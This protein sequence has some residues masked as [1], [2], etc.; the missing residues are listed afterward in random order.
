MHIF[1][2]I[3]LKGLLSTFDKLFNFFLKKRKTEVEF[4]NNKLNLK[5]IKNSIIINGVNVEILFEYDPTVRAG[6]VELKY[7]KNKQVAEFFANK[8][9]NKIMKVYNRDI[10]LLPMPSSFLRNKK[11]GY[12]HI[13]FLC[14][15]GDLS[16]LQ[17]IYPLA[18]AHRKPQQKLTRK[19]RLKN[20]KNA[21]IMKKNYN[22][23]NRQII[24]IDDVTTTGTTLKEAIKT[25]K[26]AGASKLSAIVIAKVENTN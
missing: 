10:W 25:L 3:K 16:K 7:Y 11:R 22:L 1:Y 9:Y 18:R 21:F 24:L 19:E 17:K 12:D 14:N 26:K 5:T 4:Q 23:K 20:L 15:S 6:I 13:K 2:H 8:I